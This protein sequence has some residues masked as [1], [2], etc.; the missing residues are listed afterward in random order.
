MMESRGRAIGEALLLLFCSVVMSNVGVASFIAVA[1]L[2]LFSIRHGRRNGLIL[3]AIGFIVGSAFSFIVGGYAGAGRLGASILMIDLYVPLSL[4]AAGMV[5]LST[6]GGGVLKRLLLSLLPSF[7]LLGAYAA[8]FCSDRALLEELMLAVENAFAVIASPLLEMVAPG[9]D[10]G[11][12]A[13]FGMLAIASFVLPAVLCGICASC[14][15]YE[16]ARHSRESGWEE[17]V[18]RLE[19]PSDAVWGFIV[20]WALVLMF[21]FVSVP[22]LAVLAVV[23]VAGAWTVI[24]AVEGFSVVFARIRRHSPHMRSM[25]LLIVVLM[26]AILVPG[27]NLIVLLGFPLVGILESFFDLKKLGGNGYEDHS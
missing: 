25:T 11:L 18:M 22:L 12:I 27:I 16:T 10:I 7:L 24:Y 3:I 9:I 20:S 4:S 15:I 19:Y 14:F 6:R 17:K 1:P 23:N 5:W 26:V 8:F 13:Y 21:R 2:M